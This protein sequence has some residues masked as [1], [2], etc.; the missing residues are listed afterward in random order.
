MAE[1]LAVASG[2][3]GLLSLG[4]QAAQ[5]LISFYTT[6]KDHDTDLAKITQN[7]NNLQSL[8]STFRALK[9]AVDERRS[10]AGTLDLLREVEKAVQH[11]EE[12]ITELQNECEKF[13]KDSVAGL[14]DRVKVAGRRAAYP[15]WKSTLQKLE[16]DV[17]DIRE[18]LSFA[19]DVLQ[20]KSQSQVHDDLSEVKSLV[21]RTNASQVSLTI[22]CWLMAPGASLNHNATHAKCHPGTGLWFVNGHQLR[23]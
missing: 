15:F 1:S 18:N 8:Q 2:I 14:K 5:S 4:I 10:Q 6:Y 19:L 16:E 13:H 21:E 11:C 9:V 3:A 20:L 22:R 17:S 12:V 23:T 7:L